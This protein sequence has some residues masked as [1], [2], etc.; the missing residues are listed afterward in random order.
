MR[1]QP[2][3]AVHVSLEEIVGEGR[4][5]PHADVERIELGLRGQLLRGQPLPVASERL[6]QPASEAD[7]DRP[8]AAT[9]PAMWDSTFPA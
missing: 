4:A 9:Y 7:L 3:D 2:V 6:D 1:R 5:A 8:R